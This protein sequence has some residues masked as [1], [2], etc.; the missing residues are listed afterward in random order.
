VSTQ[1]ACSGTIRKL[2]YLVWASQPWINSRDRFRPWGQTQLWGSILVPKTKQTARGLTVGTRT[3]DAVLG[4]DFGPQNRARLGNK[5]DPSGWRP[6]W[7][8]AHPQ[9]WRVWWV[10]GGA[11]DC[12]NFGVGE[13]HKICYGVALCSYRKDSDNTNINDAC[14]LLSVWM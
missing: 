2:E 10:V 7:W 13:V 14:T 9:N 5:S 4:V 6:R 8:C 11:A 12:S 3:V 1:Q